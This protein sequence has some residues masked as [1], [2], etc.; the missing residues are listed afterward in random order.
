MGELGARLGAVRDGRPQGSPIHGHLSDAIPGGGFGLGFAIVSDP[1]ARGQLG[2]VGEYSWG[3]AYQT[4][5]WV[6]PV[7]ELT[8]VYM[9]QVLPAFGLDD[10]GKVGAGARRRAGEALAALDGDPQST[11]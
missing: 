10:F 2:S 6:D 3:G 9:T 11:W 8:V 1:G 7:E 4:P 5:F